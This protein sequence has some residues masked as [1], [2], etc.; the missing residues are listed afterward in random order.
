MFEV[1]KPDSLRKFAM[2]LLGTLKSPKLWNRFPP[3]PGLVPA[4]M[5]YWTFP[6]G[7]VE[8]A[9]TCVL[10]PDDVMGGV[11]CAEAMRETN[12]R[13]SEKPAVKR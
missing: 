8:G 5:S 13:T 7:S 12:S 9:E 4:V 11:V 3:P 6:D 10:S 1:A 2:L